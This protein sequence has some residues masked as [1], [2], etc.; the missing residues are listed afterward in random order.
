M[1]KRSEYVKSFDDIK[2][3][4]FSIDDEQLLQGYEL[5][6]VGIT[7]MQYMKYI[8]TRIKTYG[9]K[10]NDTGFYKSGV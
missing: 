4:F 2:L 7:R 10:V 6:G 8:K 9:N 5:L 1:P 3:M